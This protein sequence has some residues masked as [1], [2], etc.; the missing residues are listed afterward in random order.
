MDDFTLYAVRSPYC[1]WISYSYVSEC[2]ASKLHH[3]CYGMQSLVGAQSTM[4]HY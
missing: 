3:K 4:H 2:I 1:I